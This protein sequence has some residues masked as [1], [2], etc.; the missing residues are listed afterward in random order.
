[1]ETR[2]LETDRGDRVTYDAHGPVG[3]RRAVVFVAGAGP[4]RA[5][6]PAT[7]ACAEALAARGVPALVHDR[8]GRAESPADGPI[9]LDREA[10]PGGALAALVAAAGGDAVLCGHSSGGAIAL[11]A[12]TE[13]GVP[14]A[15]LALFEAPLDPTATGVGPWTL[16]VERFLDA[17]EDAE[18]LTHYLRDLP[19]EL[20]GGLRDSPVWPVWVAN[21]PALRVDAQA[22]RWAYSAPYDVQLGDRLGQMA[23]PV[24]AAYGTSTF[25][26]MPL[27]AEAVAAAVPGARAVEVAGANHTWDPGAMADLLA[28]LAA[29]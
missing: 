3:E 13:G 19:P 7:T 27:A 25:P 26:E 15:G 4:Y 29:G 23:V 22:L 24:V 1:M 14:V 11:Y 12:A 18:A 8:V 2:T 10:G 9:D 20:V 5:I 16:E 21:A 28:E 6:D 17:G